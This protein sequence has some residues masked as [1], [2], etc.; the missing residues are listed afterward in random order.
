MCPRFGLTKILWQPTICSVGIHLDRQHQ[1]RRAPIQNAFTEADQGIDVL[2]HTVGSYQNRES[3]AR[4]LLD[5]WRLKSVRSYGPAHSDLPSG[6]PSFF[7]AAKVCKKFD[8]K[9]ALKQKNRIQLSNCGRRR[10][11][12]WPF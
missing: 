11:I 10:N 2:T 9:T 6:A 12:E 7:E 4:F 8:I 1:V 3:T 5:L